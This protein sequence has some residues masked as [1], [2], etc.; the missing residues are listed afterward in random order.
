MNQNGMPAN[1]RPAG[2]SPQGRSFRPELARE[3][4]NVFRRGGSESLDDYLNNINA[5][6]TD[7]KKWLKK[8]MQSR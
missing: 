1:D 7:A 6:L 5:Y 4:E 8:L 3:T 2:A